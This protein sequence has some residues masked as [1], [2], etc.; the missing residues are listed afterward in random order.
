VPQVVLQISILYYGGHL[1]IS[2]QMTSG[3]LIS[4]V[5]YEF[6]LG[7]C[8]E[9]IGSVYGGLM[10]G[11]G[12]AEKVFEFIDRQ[13]KIVNDGALAPDNLEGKVE[14]RNIT[15]TYPTRPAAQVLKVS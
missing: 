2:G 8:I 1:V 4:F 13:P 7:D 3:N 14:F 9:S 11:V 6:L 12:A 15:F 10:Q 5:I